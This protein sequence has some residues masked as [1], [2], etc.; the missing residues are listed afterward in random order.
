MKK[1]QIIESARNLFNKYGY[2]KVSMD[3]IARDAGVT[4]R[5]VYMYFSS[6]EDILKYFIEEE[7]N[8]MKKII[9]NIESKNLDFFDAIH[10]VIYSLIKYK[11]SR[12]FLKIIFEESEIIKNPDLLNNLKPIDNQIKTYIL[13]KL[14]FAIE[15]E[16]IETDNPEIT[17]FLIYKMYIALMFDWNEE[18]KKLDEKSIADNILK[19]ARNGLEKRGGN[20]E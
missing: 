15:K 14:N 2:K 16:Y 10:Q 20:N 12:K 4:K 1:E 18:N 17:A 7:L 8:N 3:E 6:K 13:K 5:T 9:E 11:H 19:I